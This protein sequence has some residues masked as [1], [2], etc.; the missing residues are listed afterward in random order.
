M[1]SQVQLYQGNSREGYVL[2]NLDWLALSLVVWLILQLVRLWRLPRGVFTHSSYLFLLQDRSA[3]C[4]LI[5]CPHLWLAEH[6]FLDPG[7]HFWETET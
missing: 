4:P 6:E 1:D 2:L 3:R 7:S 5:G